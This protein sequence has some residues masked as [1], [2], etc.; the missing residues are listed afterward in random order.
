MCLPVCHLVP[1]R[2][3]WM[4]GV[5]THP[6]TCREA[7]SCLIPRDDNAGC[8]WQLDLW[9]GRPA[10][11]R[12]RPDAEPLETCREQCPLRPQATQEAL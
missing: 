7:G 4:K 11:H 9:R 1:R 6:N 5:H 3:M 10:A 8:L 12:T 2:P